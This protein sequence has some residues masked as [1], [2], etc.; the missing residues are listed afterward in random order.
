LTA[1]DFQKFISGF[2]VLNPELV[3]CNLVKSNLNFDLT[4]EKVEDVPEENK[5][6]MLQL[7]LFLQ[8]PFLPGEKNVKYAIENL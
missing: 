4:I 5:N 7:E 3:I 2:Q 1:G 8:T 6:R